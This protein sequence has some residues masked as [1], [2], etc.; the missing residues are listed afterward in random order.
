MA[1]TAEELRELRELEALESGNAGPDRIGAGRAALQGINSGLATMLG[2]PVDLANFALRGVGLNSE[3]PVGGSKF[4][5]Q[6]LSKARIGTFDKAADLHPSDRPFAVG[7][8]TFGSSLIPG[9]GILGAATKTAVKGPSLIAPALEMAR[10]APGRF[11]ATEVGLGA[12]SAQGAGIA[13]LI[14]PGNENA[15]LGGEIVG[16]FVNPTQAISKGGALVKDNLQRVASNFSQSGRER[17]AA[18]IVQDV[19]AKTGENKQAVIDALRAADDFN[20]GLTSGQK[21]ASPALLAIESRLGKTSPQFAA[22][23]EQRVPQAFERLQGA[24]ENIIRTGD[25]AALQAAAQARLGRTQGLAR[26]RAQMAE[27]GATAARA[28]IGNVSR[29]EMI[30]AS[31][32]ARDT[33]GE[34]LSAAR[35]TE[36]SLWQQIPKD[37]P[38][39]ATNVLT[40][41]QGIRDELLPNESMPQPVETFT[42]NLARQADQPIDTG[43]VSAS[44]SPITRPGQAESSSGGLLRLRNR[45]LTEARGARARGDFQLERQMNKIAEGAL[46]DLSALGSAAIDPARQFSRQLNDQFTRGF[47]GRALETGRTGAPRIEPEQMLERAFG[48]GG[49]M[50]NVRMRQLSEASDFSGMGVEMLTQQDR[51]LRGAVQ[52]AIDQQTGRVNPDKL[53]AFVR[54]N[55][56][57]LGR[58]PELRGQLNNAETAQREFS[59]ISAITDKAQTNA[60]KTLFAKVA[61]AEN[62]ASVVSQVMRG[63]NPIGDYESLVRSAQKAGPDAV[64]GLRASTLEAAFKSATKSDGSLDFDKLGQIMTKP[65]SYQNNATSLFDT[66]VKNNVLDKSGAERLRAMF[67][68]AST[69]QKARSTR[70]DLDRLVGEPDML[71]NFLQRVVGANIGGAMGKGTGAPLVAAGAGSRLAQNFFDKLPAAKVTEVLIEAANNPSMMKMLLEKPANVKQARE[72]Q[73]QINGFLVSAGVISMQDNQQERRPLQ[74]SVDAFAQ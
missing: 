1:L 19:I 33:L 24:G 42:G 29:P 10:Q 68:R 41:R 17:R 31:V 6:A 48:G 73:K 8:E 18:D 70:S 16:G 45:A 15:R 4:L 46:E 44:G 56:S 12:G 64:A 54:Q 66:M 59:R 72:L 71:S 43:I 21:T 39:P 35:G 13:E 40:A 65:G 22:S 60:A 14:A 9:M 27:Q 62:P 5:K 26:T 74:Q 37:L 58:F 34:A 23:A 25:P 69:L 55:E 11:A 63:N 49:T 53:A 30:D 47:G 67:E 32:A 28:P 7:G 51:F 50:G 3:A 20:L 38:S 36:S 61:G 2:A 57:L 52:S